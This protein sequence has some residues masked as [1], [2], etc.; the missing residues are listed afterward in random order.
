ML[1][2]EG[3]ISINKQVELKPY[4][5]RSPKQYEL[6]TDNEIWQNAGGML[7]GDSESYLNYFLVAFKCFK[8]GKIIGM[9]IGDKND[10]NARKLAFILQSY[11]IIG[12]NFIKYDRPV[13]WF[14]HYNP[15]P[16]EIQQVS[17][18]II[19]GWR[20]K[21]VEEKYN[22]K[23][24]KTKIIDLI[25]VCPLKGSLKLYGARINSPRIQD[26][27]FSVAEPLPLEKIQ[28]VKDYC[29]NDLDETERL[30]IYLKDRL[31]LRQ[32]MSIEYREDLMSKSDAQ[33]AESIIG[34]E[35]FKKTGRYPKR[36]DI[37]EN[38]QYQYYV[39]DFL[40]YKTS[41]MKDVLEKVRKAKFKPH[42]NGYLDVPKELMR[43]IQI[44]QSFY[45]MGIGGLHS[46]E[47]SISYKDDADNLIIDRDVVSYYPY[48]ILNQG[49][50]PLHI[51]PEFLEIYRS[52]VERRLAAKK[53]GNKTADKGLKITINGTFG[54][55][56]S[57]WS[58]LRSPEMFIQ[59]VITGQLALLMLIE[60]M[61]KIG[62]K[63]ISANTDGV[64][65]LCPHSSLESLN[66]H[67][68]QWELD[69]DFT[70]EETRYKA[71][72]A[73]DVNC[74]FAVKENGEVKVKGPYS[75]TGGMTGTQ[76]DTNPASLICSDAVK[77]LLSK[78][79][80]IEKTIMECQDIRRF[81]T[82]RNVKGGAH[83]N[84]EYLGKV[85]RWYMSKNVH[86]TI[87]YIVSDNKVPDTEGAKPAMD[88]PSEF[89][90]DIDYQWYL[91]RAR[92]ILEE[93]A[94]LP[95]KE[96]LKFF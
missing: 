69:T 79:T 65:I 71:Y 15:D 29:V 57:Y 23:M 43:P 59:I 36:P 19:N 22:F 42:E 68:H 40:T 28:I 85:V 6:M 66:Q 27:P 37:D 39:P 21:D 51:G 58:F 13:L 72:Y 17:W 56:A 80:P 31:E 77:E 53:S 62:L 49:L 55:T 81:I 47:K 46:L 8:T 89:P 1:T 60:R 78:G 33:I 9:D 54:K 88:L 35:L 67:I 75:E 50:Y 84:N 92:N 87:N 74:Y 94:Y 91:N 4:V 73:R 93:I 18:N 96:Q 7:I 20:S 16:E 86:G 90:S 24:P 70:T 76:L 52:I 32:A 2:S 30:Y 45:Q 11:T 26:L 44:G 3:L 83:K 64:V 61:E 41:V 82:V 48:I 63:V 12:F 95:R 10:F 38:K 25:E 14:A 5:A 34:K